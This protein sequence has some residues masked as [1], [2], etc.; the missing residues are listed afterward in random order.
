MFVQNCKINLLNEND[1][2]NT[3]A[4]AYESKITQHNNS[5]FKTVLHFSKEYDVVNQLLTITPI[6]SDL[7]HIVM[8]YINDRMDV[9]CTMTVKYRNDISTIYMLFNM[10]CNIWFSDYIFETLMVS[11]LD[12]YIEIY[13][14]CK[15]D[16]LS[17]SFSGSTIYFCDNEYFYIS[18]AF[19]NTFVESCLYN[20]SYVTYSYLFEP[21]KLYNMFAILLRIKQ[22]LKKIDK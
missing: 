14:D 1:L 11:T 21:S 12:N 8:S 16:V 7:H 20:N 6:I 13:V 19:V 9:E 3:Y 22:A 4:L 10:N 18:D 17:R 5:E 2:V 15:N